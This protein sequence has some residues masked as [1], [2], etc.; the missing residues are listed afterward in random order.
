VG[1]SEERV[2]QRRSLIAAQR[3]L[4]P[5]GPLRKKRLTLKGFAAGRTRSGFKMVC[6]TPGLS[7]APTAGL[8]LANAFGVPVTTKLTHYPER[9]DLW[10]VLAGDVVFLFESAEGAAI[11]AGF[12]RCARDVAVVFRQQRFHVALLK[13]L[14]RAAS[15]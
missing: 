5:W 1:Q 8:Q 14:Y 4:Q 9:K 10:L 12:E 2:R 3:L 13:S 6:L 15:R 7:L 11:L